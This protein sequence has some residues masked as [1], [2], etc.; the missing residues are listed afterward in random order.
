LE[1]R[2]LQ[3]RFFDLSGRLV[4]EMDQEIVAGR[5][6]FVWDGRD[7]LGRLVSPGIYVLRMELEGDA[8]SENVSRIVSVVY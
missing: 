1:N 6:Q 2:L 4:R 3:L 7:E 5:Q 8:R